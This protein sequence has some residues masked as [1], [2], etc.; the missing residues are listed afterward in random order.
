MA[1]ETV[2]M[3]EAGVSTLLTVTKLRIGVQHT[4]LALHL[5]PKAGKFVDILRP[6]VPQ[7]L[8]ELEAGPVQ[9]MASIVK[10]ESRKIYIDGSAVL[11][12][13]AFVKLDR[14][15]GPEASYKEMAEQIR[16][17]EDTILNILSVEEDLS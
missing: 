5:Q 17:D 3:L 2:A 15:F 11:A 8:I 4:S 9:T 12:N 14:D 16:A 1:E 6:F 7:Q 10:W 13:A